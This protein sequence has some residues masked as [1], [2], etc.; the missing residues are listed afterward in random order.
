MAAQSLCL[1]AQDSLENEVERQQI[2]R[3]LPRLNRK[4]KQPLAVSAPPLV[5][6]SFDLVL[7]RSQGA[8]E[9][10]V[11]DHIEPGILRSV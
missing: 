8:V 7:D 1:V 5:V 6:P 4:L 10:Q 3:I 11:R 9:H 2:A